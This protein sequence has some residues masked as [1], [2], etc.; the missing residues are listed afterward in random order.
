MSSIMSN[1]YSNINFDNAFYVGKLSAGLITLYLFYKTG[2]MYLHRRKYRHIPGPPT[3]GF[4]LI[5]I[6]ILF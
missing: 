1:L 2:E 3:K 6:R 4:L 5:N